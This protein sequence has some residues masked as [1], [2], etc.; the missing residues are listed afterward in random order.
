MDDCI[1][2]KEKPLELSF[3]WVHSLP[4]YTAEALLCFK[5]YHL[6]CRSISQKSADADRTLV[7]QSASPRST[8][9][10]VTPHIES[11][12]S[13]TPSPASTESQSIPEL[14]SLSPPTSSSMRSSKLSSRGSFIG[15]SRQS[16]SSG[17]RRTAKTYNIPATASPGAF[18]RPQVCMNVGLKGSLAEHH[19]MIIISPKWQDGNSYA[20]VVPF[21]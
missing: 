5:Y 4:R 16:S 15:Y 3:H 9:Q 13:N 10:V 8:Y 19:F 17:G 12:G 11:P 14:P 2:L 1:L 21:E 20:H 6:F 7:I 18:T